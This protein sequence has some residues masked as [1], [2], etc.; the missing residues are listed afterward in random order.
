MEKKSLPEKVAAALEEIKPY[1]VADGGDLELVEVTGEGEV[2]VRL[3]GACSSCFMGEFTL[4][5]VVEQALREKVPQIKRV[6][7]V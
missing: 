3:R 7:A 1:L 4:K 6:E 5:M 2:K